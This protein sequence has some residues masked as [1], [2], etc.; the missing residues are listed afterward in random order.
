MRM[1]IALCLLAFGGMLCGCSSPVAYFPANG[2]TS[3]CPDAPLRVTLHSTTLPSVLS[4]KIEIISAADNGP[5]ETIDLSKKT[6]VKSI[7][8]L[9]NYNYYSVM[10]IGKE[11]AIYP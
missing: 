6:A 9:A 4:G 3:V 7:G 10:A 1:A 2:A 11:L 8:G 5:V